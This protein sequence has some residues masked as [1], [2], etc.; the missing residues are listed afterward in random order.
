MEES[1]LN[2]NQHKELIKDKI[3]IDLLSDKLWRMQNLYPIRTKE[4]ELLRFKMNI[5]QLRL[6]IRIL[7]K[8]K[9]QDFSPLIILKARQVGISTFCALWFLDDVL[10]YEGRRAV[11]QSQKIETMNAIFDVC[12]NSFQFMIDVFAVNKANKQFETINDKIGRISIPHTGSFIESKLEVRSTATNMM[13]FSEYS[14]MELKRIIASIGS[15]SLNCLTIYESTPN[16]L[17]HFYDLYKEQKSKN[18]KNTIFIPWYDH[19]EYRRQVGK[20]GLGELT[21]EEKELKKN[22][23]LDDEQLNFR[24]FRSEQMRFLDESHSTF[25]QEYPDDDERCFLMSGIGPLE[26]EYLKAVKDQCDQT[27]PLEQ[28]RDGKLLIKIFEKIDFDKHQDT[29]DEDDPNFAIYCG[30]DPA[31]GVNR[32]YSVA[33][34]IKADINGD[35]NVLMTMRGYENPVNFAPLIKK[36]LH[37]Y[38][39]IW[40][41]EGLIE[42]EPR[43][44][45]ERNGPGN[46]VLIIFEED[47]NCRWHNLYRHWVQL[48]G[49]MDKS[50]RSGF[51]TNAGSK[52]AIMQRLFNTIR[53]G[54]IRINDPVIASELRT[55]I[56]SDTNKIEATSGK[57]DDTI[58][59]LALC[60]QAYSKRPPK[61]RGYSEIVCIR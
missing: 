20:E 44:I 14:F 5:H 39:T 25:D 58:M 6:A 30:V 18:P 41:E 50:W 7:E 35:M 22:K 42:Y 11:I 8:I 53:K 61:P 43:V 28:F 45:V 21:P 49:K 36:Y 60:I 23:K 37:K 48:S 32:D 55:L 13:L 12:R 2:F 15:L 29:T 1:P 38:Y 3:T 40:N 51:V 26:G 52:L 59:A 33:V 9:E 56:I 34:V 46:S 17:N 57:H 4:G 16:G 31:Q 10:F 27:K 54:K 47:P 19:P 24:R